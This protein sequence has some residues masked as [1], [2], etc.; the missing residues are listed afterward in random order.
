MIT[1]TEVTKSYGRLKALDSIKL[2]FVAGQ[3][4][5]LLGPNGSGKTTMI[6]S[7]L[8]MIKIDQGSIYFDGKDVA[9][10]HMYRQ[11]IGYMPQ[12]DRYPERMRVG[13]LFDLIRGIRSDL[14]N[15]VLDE[16]LIEEYRLQEIWAQEM[17]SL[18]GGTRQKVAAALAF[19]CSPRALLLDEPMAGL[20]PLAAMTL[21][22]K[23]KAS[24]LSGKL[25]LISSHLLGEL[26]DIYTHVLYI[27]EGSI[28]FYL[29]RTEL[30]EATGETGLLQAVPV[31]MQS[32]LTT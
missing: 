16:E 10:S 11:H 32:T 14:D 7:V 28:V 1:L 8:R 24:H 21:R 15:P 5:A 27:N 17:F 3:C 4:V 2:D 30:Q 29:S 20:D 18:S 23:I 13:E 9:D 19:L 6:K 26:D 22:K 25:V 31:M 12:V